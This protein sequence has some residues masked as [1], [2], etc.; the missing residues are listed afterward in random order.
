VLA[1]NQIWN[2]L[3]AFVTIVQIQLASCAGGLLLAVAYIVSYDNRHGKQQ[4]SVMQSN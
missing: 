3:C 4:V 1:A 2:P